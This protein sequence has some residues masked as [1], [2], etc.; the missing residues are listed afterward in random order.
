MCDCITLV[1]Q[2]LA[3]NNTVLSETSMINMK[4]GSIRQ[5]LIIRTERLSRDKPRTRV[6]MVI[7]SFCPF[8]GERVKPEPVDP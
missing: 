5:S 2:R 3:E 7:P 6:K 1:N 4:T 8:C